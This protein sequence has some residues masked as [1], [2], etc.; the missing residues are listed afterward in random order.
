[1]VAETLTCSSLLSGASCEALIKA[2]RVVSLGAAG[3]IFMMMVP[4]LAIFLIDFVT[5]VVRGMAETAQRQRTHEFRF[6]STN[7]IRK[8][9]QSVSTLMRESNARLRRFGLRV[10]DE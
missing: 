6:K 8:Y 10:E 5:Y 4:I 1:M 3:F 2:E 7:H 9:F